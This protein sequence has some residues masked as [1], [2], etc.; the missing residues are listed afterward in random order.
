MAGPPARPDAPPAVGAALAVCA[1]GRVPDL[2]HHV[3]QLDSLAVGERIDRELR[4]RIAAVRD[5]GPGGVRQLEV[6]RQEVSLVLPCNVVI[7]ATD[8]GTRVAAVDPHDLMDDPRFT[9][10]TDE[11]A[12]RLRAVINAVGR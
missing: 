7:E 3:A 10:L 9:A 12:Q 8:T 6:A 4:P 5:H 2:Q 11:A 1:P